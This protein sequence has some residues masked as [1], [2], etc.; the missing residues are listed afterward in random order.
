[1]F[2]QGN[3]AIVVAEIH[4]AD[5]RHADVR[6]V[7]EEQKIVGEEAKERVGRRV[8][9]AARKRPAVVLDPRT[10][11][12]FFEHFDVESRAGAE[13]L[14]LEQFALGLELVEPLF[15]F[16]FDLGHSP[17]DSFFR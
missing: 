12:Y 2:D 3:F 8:G 9:R 17:G 14:G 11:A 5:L 7:D 1:M 13:A 6:L 16:P 4:A 10:V 15:Q